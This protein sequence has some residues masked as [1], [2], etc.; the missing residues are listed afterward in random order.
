MRYSDLKASMDQRFKWAMGANPG[1]K[2]VLDQFSCEQQA[3]LD[4]VRQLS[5]LVKIMVGVGQSA[6]Q[7]EALRTSTVEGWRSPVPQYP[8]LL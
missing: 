7:F 6:L 8:G 2:E 1:L 3:Q 5:T 4:I